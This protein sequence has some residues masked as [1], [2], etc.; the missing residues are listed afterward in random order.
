MEHTRF[1][2]RNFA[3][4]SSV[5]L[6]LSM[7]TVGFGA[8]DLA[9]VAPKGLDSVA[10]V[11]QAD[12]LVSGIYAFFIGA[13][14]VFASRVAIAEGEGSTARRLPVVALAL[15][16]LLVP[17]QVIGSLLAAGVEPVLSFFGQDPALVPQVGDYV[18]VRTSAVIPVILYIV[19]SES[20]K[21]CGL[22]N[23]SVATL[24]CGFVVNAALNWLFLY[25]GLSGWFSSPAGAVAWSTV[26]TQTLMA[27]A[28][29]VLLG[30]Q[31]KA[32]RTPFR[33]PERAEV[34]AEFRSMA[35][36]AP[37]IGARHLN[38]YAGTIVPLLFIGTMGVRVTAAAMVAT[39]IYTLF[40]RVPQACFAGVFVF[41]G[42][43]LGQD[44]T[45][46]AALA[47]KVRRYA[48]VPTAVAAVVT[49]AALPW[50]VSAFAGPG[51]DRGLAVTLSLAY[52]VYLPAYFFEQLH[53]ELLTVHQSGRLLFA[54]ST[55]LT[56]ALAIP[57]A[58]F[59]V[60]V[61]HSAFLA[62]AS[63]GLSTAALA[64]VFWHGLRRRTGQT[65]RSESVS[66]VQIA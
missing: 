10:A 64:L 12:V 11:G 37:G 48:A 22:K 45:D 38:D 55:V 27:L 36:T 30:R 28:G 29:A 58:W 51:L 19:I 34:A 47:R 62:I 17:C 24:C 16:G 4:L 14:D 42:Y 57:T 40:C 61:A 52:L 63:K 50:L 7:V 20:L 60:F 39:K 32:R 23:L 54:A 9:M 33:K 15:L 13:V 49:V 56:Y 6:G 59:S 65:V 66:E 26:V 3:G 2:V 1:T 35:R 46:L 5:I 31:L 41:Y 43:A 18:G 53:G 21:I 8:L 44:G 25:T